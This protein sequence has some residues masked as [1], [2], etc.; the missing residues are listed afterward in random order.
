MDISR[1]VRINLVIDHRLSRW[2][3]NWGE[4][5]GRKNNRWIRI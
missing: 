5:R 1:N 3:D 4:D 2:M